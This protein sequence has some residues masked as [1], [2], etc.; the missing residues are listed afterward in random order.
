MWQ[1]SGFERVLVRGMC[2]YVYVSTC[3]PVTQYL[4]VLCDVVC[5]HASAHQFSH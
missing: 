1:S 5:V 2:V 4:M 3:L